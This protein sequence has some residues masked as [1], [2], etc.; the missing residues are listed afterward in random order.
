MY[1]AKKAK[2]E[3]KQLD[4]M[5]QDTEMLVDERDEASD[6]SEMMEVNE[7]ERE[8]EMDVEEER[9]EMMG[10]LDIDELIRESLHSAAAM[11]IEGSN[12]ADRKIHRLHTLQELLMPHNNN[13]GNVVQIIATYIERN[14]FKG[15]C[16]C[17]ILREKFTVSFIKCTARRL[18]MA[19]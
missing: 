9:V 17:S 5:Q 14:S 19:S 8:E 16:E 2:K 10:E 1:G 3:T 15:I 11:L 12:H 6:D 4:V 7:E 13:K 18:K